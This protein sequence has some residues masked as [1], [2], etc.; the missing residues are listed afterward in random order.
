MGLFK[1]ASEMSKNIFT[2]FEKR[3]YIMKYLTNVSQNTY[4]YF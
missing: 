2:K 4:K 1:I 3:F